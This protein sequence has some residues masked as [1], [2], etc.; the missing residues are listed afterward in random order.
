VKQL[1]DITQIKAKTI[2]YNLKNLKEAGFV[3]HDS[4]KDRFCITASGLAA[5]NR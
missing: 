3:V 5:L 1:E 4:E 2:Y